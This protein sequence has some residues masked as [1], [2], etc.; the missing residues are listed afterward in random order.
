MKIGLHACAGNRR[1][2]GVI[3]CRSNRQLMNQPVGA[4]RTCLPVEQLCLI[5][6]LDDARHIPKRP[7]RADRRGLRDVARGEMMSDKRG[8]QG[9]RED[10]RDDK[11][12]LGGE[13]TEA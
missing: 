2:A 12:R 11:E 5:G 9:H 13:A 3:A 10:D 8:S 1:L 6:R 7:G 4:A